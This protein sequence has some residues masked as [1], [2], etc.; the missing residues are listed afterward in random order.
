[1]KK[2]I[3]LTVFINFIIFTA[4]SSE[5]SGTKPVNTA[6]SNTAN[7]NA[8]NNSVAVVDTDNANVPPGNADFNI[9][10]AVNRKIVNAPPN[11]KEPGAVKP[12]AVAAPYNSTMVST[13]SKQNEFLE[14]REFQ[15]DPLL[16]RVERTQQN[17]KIKLFLKNG[18]VIEMPYD[19]NAL[20]LVASPNEL[21]SAAGV[22]LPTVKPAEGEVKKVPNDQKKQ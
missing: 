5:T 20:F 15:G 6:N 18:K 16:L 21:L 11:Y 2:F 17:Q 22:K 14:I 13:M 8:A 12:A 10:Q 1:M 3:L 9:Q 7:V 19:K 4:C